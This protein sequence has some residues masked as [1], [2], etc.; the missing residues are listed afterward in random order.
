MR[1]FTF[2]ESQASVSRAI[3]RLDKGDVL[4]NVPLVDNEVIEVVEVLG[5]SFRRISGTELSMMNLTGEK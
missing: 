2:Y 4:C 5:G 1:N 3:T